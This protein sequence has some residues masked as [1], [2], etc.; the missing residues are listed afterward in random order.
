MCCT[1]PL[2][3]IQ[4]SLEQKYYLI[5]GKL[6]IRSWVKLLYIYFTSFAPLKVLCKCLLW[7]FTDRSF[8]SC[9]LQAFLSCTYQYFIHSGG[10]GKNKTAVPESLRGFNVVQSLCCSSMELAFLCL[11]AASRAHQFDIQTL[12]TAST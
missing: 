9:G 12:K 1:V 5:L 6:K 10:A 7:S 3:C 2:K 11:F 8:A 4:S